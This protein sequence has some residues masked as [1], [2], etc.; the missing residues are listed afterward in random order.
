[1]TRKRSEAD[2]TKLIHDL[3]WD[4]KKFEDKRFCPF[5][6]KLQYRVDNMPYDGIATIKGRAIPVEVKSGTT[7][8]GF[9]ELKE[10]QREGLINWQKKHGA[11]AWLYLQMGVSRVDSS[12]GDRLRS[13]LMPISHFLQVEN[14]VK[15]I[16]K[17]EGVALSEETTNRRDIIDNKL[18]ATQLF[19]NYEL[20]WIEKQGWSIPEGHLFRLTYL[21]IPGEE[22][23]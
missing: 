21:H 3:G 2:F 15:G 19:K 9:N 8:F 6:K 5:C 13:W 22:T 12:L 14:L 20:A 16:Y 1:M 11:M 17:Y 18:Y 23:P 10:H 7:R 4:W